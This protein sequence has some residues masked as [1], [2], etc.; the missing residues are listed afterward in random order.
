MLAIYPSGNHFV[1]VNEEHF[2]LSDGT[3]ISVPAGFPFDGHSIPPGFRWFLNPASADMRA[4]LLHDYLYFK[5]E[6]LEINLT[7]YQVDQEYLREL[8]ACGTNLARRT[9][10]YTGVR[11][12]GWLWWCF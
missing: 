2:T 4:A 9:V 12:F 5:R 3:N 1:T 6:K 11:L 8:K 7:R 10:L